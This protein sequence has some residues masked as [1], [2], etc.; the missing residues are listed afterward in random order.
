[1]RKARVCLGVLLACFCGMAH[2]GS[3]VLSATNGWQSVRL[4]VAG[5][6]GALAVRQLENGNGFA[7][8]DGV[9][10]R[11]NASA[12]ADVRMTERLCASGWNF[13]GVTLYSDDA[14]YWMLS[15]VEC[16]DGAHTV[17]FIE[18]LN[19][20]WQA[21]NNPK[22]AL[23]GEGRIAFAWKA[24]AAYRLKLAFR[25]GRVC[26]EVSD[27]ADGRVLSSAS[28]ALN[29]AV[30][31]KSGRPGVIAH[32]SA[33]VFG[34]LRYE[35]NDAPERG[36]SVALLDDALPG[37][38]R[39][40]NAR[41]AAALERRGLRVARLSAAQFLDSDVLTGDAFAACVLPSCASLPAQAGEAVL[42][43]AREGGHVVAV[44]GPFLDRALF[45]VKGRWLDK[46]GLEPILQSLVP[47][48]RPF[49]IGPEL[50]LKA[51]QRSCQDRSVASTFR[52]VNEGPGGA[53]CLRFD[54]PD[55]GGWDVMHSPA[56]G[57]L[58]GDGDTLFTFFG[59]GSP[60]TPQLSVEIIE[61][62]GSRWIA[63]SGLTPEW[64]RISLRLNE[65]HFW[66]DSPSSGV[67]G[68]A[69]DRLNPAQA[70]H[71]CF[72]FS[73]SHTASVGPGTH[74][75]WLADVGT[76]P[77]PL[78]GVGADADG[79]TPDIETLC[80]RYKVFSLKGPTDVWETRGDRSCGKMLLR[81]QRDLICAIPRTLGEGFGRLAK[82]RYIPLAQ[83][84][85][86]TPLFRACEW[87][88]LNTRTPLAGVAFAGFGYAD[89]AVWSSSPIVDRIAGTVARLTRGMLLEE[90]GTDQF[91]YWPGEP[92][93]MGARV[94]AFGAE[95]AEARVTFRILEGGRE[96]WK[97]QRTCQAVAD[98]ESVSCAWQPP[99]APGAY[100]V[101]VTVE[102]AGGTA[103]EISHPFE[104]LDPAPSAKPAFITVRDGDFW[105]NGQKWNPIGVNFW[106]LYVSGLERS[107]Y[108]S[109]WLND[110]NYSPTLVEQDLAQLQDMGVSMVSVQSPHLAS[111][112]NLLDFLTRCSRHGIHVNLYVRQASPLAFDGD[113]LKAFLDATRLPD[114]ATVFAYDTIWEPGNHVFKNDAARRRWDGDWRAWIDA[115]YGS[116]SAAERD[117]GCSARRDKRGRAVSPADAQFSADGPWRGMVAAYRRFMDDLTS[118][119]WGRAHRQLRAWD[120][121]HLISFRQGNTL[122]YDFAL[123]GPVKHIDFVCP[124]G[125]SIRDTD[126]GEDA[127]GFITRYVRHTTGGKPVM[128]S[129]F[130]K[131]VW[132]S[133][134]MAPDAGM[135]VRQGEYEERFYRTALAAG[136]NGTVPWWWVGGYR[137]DEQS[138]FGILDPDR[139]E[140][141]AARL[142]RS[143]GPQFK[144]PRGKPEAADEFVYDRDAQAGGY[145][146]TAFHDGAAAYRAARLRGHMLAV[147]TAGTGMN[148]DTAPRTAVGNT[149]CN[150][151]NPPKF[152]DAEFNYLQVCDADGVWREAEEGAVIAVRSGKPVLA[153]ASVG[154]LQEAEW[155]AA[156]PSRVALV[157]RSGD[158]A[159]V[160]EIALSGNVPFLSDAVFGAF[161]LTPEGARG[162]SPF[163]VRM[164]VTG[165][166]G[167]PF[168]EV[169]SFRLDSRK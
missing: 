50:D 113:G 29:G 80:P 93:T 98:A 83:A 145:W 103:D 81:G 110:G 163:S 75:L 92:V 52:V 33:A 66:R 54:I 7:V 46:G 82:S 12:E 10:C 78:E 123:S 72:G 23:K 167:L 3:H 137:V 11:R 158:G 84:D 107:A 154:N 161:P 14:N 27:P 119:L 136:A 76:A 63:T 109:G 16:P 115:R 21:Q 56:V 39:A 1:M 8:P 37:H 165:T 144:V 134:R 85:A 157:V 43:F 32:A 28:F 51:W 102:D 67:R 87:M 116:L 159:V 79:K 19:G 48:H 128:W 34:G 120:P 70:A 25:D 155:Q 88:L 166:V 77:D 36:N 114:N 150:G 26:A 141:P 131:S 89:P 5:S 62:D 121:H 99:N 9:P 95:K 142:I 68:G 101:R 20:V 129:E 30:A 94:L 31:V 42:R 138:D 146:W 57:K 69:G 59:K 44:G 139:T 73:S 132:D 111:C 91:A 47:A 61:R 13:A 169:R 156:S 64:R 17:D 160:K 45:Q 149:P 105:L 104:V 35:M 106:P 124:E 71:V 133:Q 74:T 168:G 151:H 15:L 24:H 41:L 148:S 90:A 143:Y 108:W 153:R 127:I 96:I 117:W 4:T 86:S 147:R 2:A 135:I 18:N 126:E 53:P 125:Y 140:R 112:R 65:F 152:L 58:F 38:D 55:L 40:A 162:Q 6:E 164:E 22:H 100:C 118:A 97:E 122:P 49:V 60:K 130:G